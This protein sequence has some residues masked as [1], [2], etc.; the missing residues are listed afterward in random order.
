MKNKKV[1]LAFSGGLDTS[2]CVRYLKNERGMEVHTALVNTG[3]FSG[4]EL[5]AIGRRALELGAVTH[6]NIDRVEEFYRKG[7]RYM[8]FGNVLR[9][10]T[11]PLSVSSERVFQ[12][13]AIAEYAKRIGAGCIAHGSTGAGNDQIRFDLVFGVVAP[14]I[15]IIAPV[16]ELS[17][18]RQAEID[19]LRGQG[20][21]YDWKKAKYSVNQGL[22][23]TSVGGVETLTADGVLPEEAFP[24]RATEKNE[25]IVTIGFEKGE[26]V[27]LDGAA[28]P[29][30]E[31]IARLH[32]V[33]APYGIGRNMHVGDTIIGIK[34][35]IG[36]EAASALILIEAHRLLEKH[37]LTKWQQ[38]W[39]DQLG[40]WYGMFMHEA[41]YLEPVMRD[42]E[43]FLD[44]SQKYV[45]GTVSVRLQSY[46][47]MA[48]GC[49]SDHD[50][51]NARFGDYGE[52]NKAF[53]GQDVEGFTRILANPVKIYYAVHGDE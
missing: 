45:T 41:Q 52:M 42:I 2:F 14:E 38:Y 39:K 11:Y 9:Q 21:D 40:T 8:I 10:N 18:S 29:P 28:M 16:R 17:L 51:M 13:L 34:G 7:I 35:R 47:F 46:H 44:A 30:A 53:T 26:P 19:Y 43:S 50:L 6:E 12:A 48:V 33:A 32:E 15:E 37:T 5:A 22:W 3:G 24:V 20:F 31:L 25:R 49:R 4:D 36:F 27:A 23:G 1:L